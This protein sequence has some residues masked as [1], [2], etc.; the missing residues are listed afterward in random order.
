MDVT[1]LSPGEDAIFDDE[2]PGFPVHK[3]S[4][5]PA[6]EYYVQA[7][8]SVYTQFH[9][10]DGNVIWAHMDQWEGQQL[11]RSPGNLYSKV[12]KVHIGGADKRYLTLE[13]TETIPA[14]QVPEDTEWV[15]HIKIESKLLTAFWGHPMYLGAVVLLP[16]GYEQN[17][18]QHYQ[19]IYQQGH[20]SLS[21]PFGF[22]TDEVIE[23]PDE[24]RIRESHGVENGFEFY[25][26]WKSDNFPRVIAVTLLHPTPFYDDSYAVDS[27]NN[28]PYGTAIMTELIPYIEAQ[29]RITKRANARVLTG[30]STGGWEALALQLFH[31]EFFGGA[32]VLYPDPVDFRRFQLIDIYRDENA[33][34]VDSSEVPVWARQDW[35]PPERSFAR[36]DDGQPVATVRQV[37]Q[38]E[39]VLGGKGRSG[40]QL[41]AWDA[42]F[43]PVGR[44]GYPQPLWDKAT[45]RIDHAV[46]RYMRD[47]GYDLRYYAET[48]WLKTGP[49]VSEKLHFYCG[50]GDNFYLNLGVYLFEQLLGRET[51]QQ[52]TGLLE[53]GR[54]L[55]GHGWQPMTNAALVRAMIEEITRRQTQVG[56]VAP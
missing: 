20:F 26:K 34:V 40:G 9:R 8:L 51:G 5:L 46:A 41:A 25:R 45:G 19:V 35:T 54:P 11:S 14:V 37:S 52:R 18:K 12:Q 49:H 30:G 3:M 6:G 43:G 32:W 22:R 47:H 38:F 1:R 10:A 53:Y 28:G 7:L 31:P 4:E 48:N 42:A 15:K 2:R 23:T 29:F 17:P 21:A 44:D 50:D 27:P 33:F 13:L 24:R 36:A 56:L 39:A 55:K 16:R